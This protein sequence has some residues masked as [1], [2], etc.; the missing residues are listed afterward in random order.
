MIV[1]FNEALGI[2]SRED[3]NGNRLKAERQTKQDALE[4]GSL[5]EV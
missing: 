5:F 2:P 3:T 4:S 1:E